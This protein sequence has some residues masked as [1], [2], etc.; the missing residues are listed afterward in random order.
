M[1]TILQYA[2]IVSSG[3][4]LSGNVALF[5]GFEEPHI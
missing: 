4:I 3:A 1:V 2:R 5:P